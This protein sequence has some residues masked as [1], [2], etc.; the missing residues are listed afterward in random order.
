MEGTFAEAAIVNV[1]QA[2]SPK[3][4]GSQR[5][6]GPPKDTLRGP[7]GA[8]KGAFFLNLISL[9]PSVPLKRT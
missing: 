2:F 4:R 8:V 6:Q 9:S 1:S 7:Q 5:P 3:H